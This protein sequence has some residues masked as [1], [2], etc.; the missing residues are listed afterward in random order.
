MSEIR[1][2]VRELES[3]LQHLIENGHGDKIVR[4]SVVYGNWKDDEPL[5]DEEVIVLLADL[6]AENKQLKQQLDYIQNSISNAIKH[7]KT[8]LQQKALK[9]VIKDYNEWMLGHKR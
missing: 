7:Q 6:T 9:E 4:V 3:Y 2:T 1:I 5:T 8:E